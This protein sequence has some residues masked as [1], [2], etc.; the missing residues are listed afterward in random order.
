MWHRLR[1]RWDTLPDPLP[2]T[3]RMT[4][5]SRKGASTAKRALRWQALR[6]LDVWRRVR[7]TIRPRKRSAR[8]LLVASNGLMADYVLRVWDCISDLPGVRAYLT[9]FRG[10]TQGHDQLRQRLG[11]RWSMSG[12][13][14]L[15]DWDM[16]ILADH[17]PL[18]YPPSIPRVIV[19]H[20]VA[21]SRLVREGSYYYDRHRVF[22]PDGRPVYDVMFEASNKARE[23]AL[24]AVPEYSSR[25]RVVGDLRV[26]ELLTHDRVRDEVRARLGWTDRCVVA[27][28]STWS[29]RALIPTQGEAL[30][31]VL[32]QLVDTGRY[33]VVLTMHPN[34][35]AERRAGSQGWRQLVQ[36]KAGEH[37]RVLQPD[38]DWASWLPLTDLAVTDHT[39]LAAAY[40]V[41]RR[42]MI[43]VD[44]PLD[45][46]GEGT[47]ARW[48]LE[49]RAR[50]SDP[51][52][53]P[54]LLEHAHVT[55][56]NWRGIPAIVDYPG[57]AR[58]RTRRVLLDVLART[59]DENAGGDNDSRG[60][61]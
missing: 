33:A 18:S 30:L 38:E 22:W 54:T 10:A 21:R 43:P 27:V 41:L 44:A 39:S 60:I 36:S 23:W 19:A 12:V 52:E 34:L 5:R 29:A 2:P 26:D 35:W 58:P 28:M 46:V 50:F 59:R 45:A 37:F 48:L 55:H 53:L 7:H 32:S 13:S 6:L 15:L 25:I 11:V 57:E 56:A 49:T 47:F 4:P 40:S 8:I 14:Q 3:R 20:G 42:P 24:T 16:L 31:T 61:V 17:A 51:A 9:R 1:G